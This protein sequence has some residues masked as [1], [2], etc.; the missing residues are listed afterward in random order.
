MKLFSKKSFV[1]VIAC[2]LSLSLLFIVACGDSG[3]A[4]R[5]AEL[6]KQLANAN[7]TIQNLQ[8]ELNTSKDTI[9]DLQDQLDELLNTDNSQLLQ[10][11]KELQKQVDNLTSLNDNLNTTIQS[12]QSQNE[13]LQQQLGESQ[14]SNKELQDL[15]ELLQSQNKELIDNITSQIEQLQ[16]LIEKLQQ[17]IDDIKNSGNGGVD[18]VY[19]VGDTYIHYNGSLKLFSITVEIIPTDN[20]LGN[21]FLITAYNFNIPGFPLATFL[22]GCA[23]NPTPSNFFH[24]G[25]EY[26]TKPFYPN[27]T[28]TDDFYIGSIT[29]IWLG[30]PTEVPTNSTSKFTP[31]VHF[32]LR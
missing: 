29:H 15:I 21:K 13:S 16:D 32:V 18:T 19:S 14:S 1:G 6:E 8:D 11:I 24:S 20:P 27:E 5:I 9:K 25:P 7:S 30:T 2:V 23:M 26:Q 17:E 3:N 4:N 12:L 28:R 22:L 31:F 10:Q